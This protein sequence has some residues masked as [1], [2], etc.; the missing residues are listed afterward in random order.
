MK[1]IIPKYITV[2]SM[3]NVCSMHVQH[4]QTHANVGRFASYLLIEFLSNRKDIRK[5]IEKVDDRNG[6]SWNIDFTTVLDFWRYSELLRRIDALVRVIF[7]Y[8]L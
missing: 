6:F 2:Q 5:A 8:I 1:H 3:Y 7:C 4:K